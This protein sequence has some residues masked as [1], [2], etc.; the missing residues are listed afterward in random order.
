MRVNIKRIPELSNK[1]RI[2]ILSKLSI[3]PVKINDK[4]MCNYK[5]IDKFKS[6]NE[7][8][9]AIKIIADKLG[10]IKEYSNIN[11]DFT[12][13]YSYTKLKE[14][15]NK[16][17]T[18]KEYKT[19]SFIKL[20]TC[21]EDVIYQSIPIEKHKD[22]YKGTI[23]ESKQLKNVYVLLG[24]FQDKKTIYP[25]E[26]IVK[27][28]IGSVGSLHMII[29]VGE[30]KKSDII[31]TPGDKLAHVGTSDTFILT[32]IINKINNGDFLKYIPDKLLSIKQKRAKYNAISKERKR[33][34][35]INSKL[36]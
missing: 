6:Q 5:H 21:I 14:S 10:I 19:S 20:L 17:Y 12:F 18:D 1:E 25:V 30:I 7:M 4:L 29:T 22:I 35:N 13:E 3:S 28:L 34:E 27:E 33:I 23:R 31:P 26:I 24:A 2:K 15:I 32:N 36:P 11:L 8:K 16:I 9:R